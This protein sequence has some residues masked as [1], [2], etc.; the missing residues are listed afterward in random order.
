MEVIKV[1][2]RD[3]MTNVYIYY[4]VMTKKGIIIDPGGDLNTINTII[5]ENFIVIEGILVTH[6]HY[7]HVADIMEMKELTGAK[8][9]ALKEEQELLQD[10]EKSLLSRLKYEDPEKST[11]KIYADE[12]LN[13]GDKITF[14]NVELEVIHT[15]GHTAGGTCYYDRKNKTIF[16]GDTLFK[17]TIGRSDLPTG[18]QDD[19]VESVC[20]KLFKLDDDVKVYPG[21]FE[22]STIG[23]E[24]EDN[25]VLSLIKG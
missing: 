16:T 4:D 24:K 17:G 1:V 21:H 12:L 20:N 11:L 10:P 9:Y 15:P 3:K 5:E 23:Q 22:M 19:L 25:F 2:T 14:N 6:A 8:I 13:D 18:N 7:D